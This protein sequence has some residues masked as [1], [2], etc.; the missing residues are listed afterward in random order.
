MLAPA[1]R[2]AR[3]LHHRE[4]GLEILQ[5]VGLRPHEHVA[6]E[7][8]VPRRLGDHAHAQ[9]IA[10]IGAGEQVL[11]VEVAAADMSARLGPEAIEP[12]GVERL[13]DVAPVD[14]GTNARTIDEEAVLGAAAGMP[15]RRRGEGA[16]DDQAAFVGAHRHLDQRRRGEIAA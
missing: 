3:A 11:D 5:L 6:R 16:V 14:R 8:A 2:A 10:R 1:R 13:V 12:R 7:Q 4:I 9:A 15:A